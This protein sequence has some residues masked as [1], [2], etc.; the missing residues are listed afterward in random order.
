MNPSTSPPGESEFSLVLGGLLHAVWLK[1]KLLEDPL[2]RLRRRMAVVALVCWFPPA[3]LAYYE[4]WFL[5]GVPIPFLYDLEVHTRFLIAVPL[6]LAAEPMVHLHL[7]HVVHQFTHAN[8]VSERSL[9]EFY[10]ARE[11]AHRRRDSVWAELGLLVL[12]VSCGSLLWPMELAIN[13]STWYAVLVPGGRRLTLAGYWYAYLSVPLFQ[14]LLLR[15]YWRIL[16][17]FLFMQRVSR[18]A[19][20]LM[21]T[22]PDRC[23]GLGFLDQSSEAFFLLILAQSSLVAAVIGNRILY[24]GAKVAALEWE[25]LLVVLFLVLVA[26]GPLFFFAPKLFALQREGVR[27]YGALALRYSAEFHSRWIQ[28]RHEARED[29]LGSSDLQS[30]ADMG[31]GYDVVENTRLVPFTKESVLQVLIPAVVPFLPLSLTL[32]SWETLLERIAEMLI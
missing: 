9:A 30:L 20:N 29:L 15:W 27:D 23:G 4:G 22:H 18:L 2:R 17:W 8:L 13:H 32:I 1:L 19:L 6:M 5:H 24:A 21:V 26:L 16:I 25:E 28:T 12:V 3:V 11:W 14:F 7:G 10:E 31:N